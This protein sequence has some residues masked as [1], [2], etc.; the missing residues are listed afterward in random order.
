MSKTIRGRSSAASA[1]SEPTQAKPDAATSQALSAA[2]DSPLTT[3]APRAAD[4]PGV[5]RV[6]RSPKNRAR[7]SRLRQE[8]AKI[9]PAPSSPEDARN[10]IVQAMYRAH[11]S[12]WAVP[13]LSDS[14]TTVCCADGS[15]RMT[16]LAHLII[17][18][19]WGAFRI[20]DLHAP[21]V[22]YFEMQGRAGRPFTLPREMQVQPVA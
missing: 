6:T 8:L 19:P 16:L 13:E 21:R 2:Q 12:G 1:Y 15:L 5:Q 4:A 7:L 22:P 14:T 17:F 18:N 20:V 3:A 10:E 11:L 9:D